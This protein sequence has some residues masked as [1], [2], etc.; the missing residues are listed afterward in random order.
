MRSFKS[1][2]EL[3]AHYAERGEP[4]SFAQVLDFTRK[5]E[6]LLN[7]RAKQQE[8]KKKLGQRR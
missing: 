8:P 1:A 7:E 6:A 4:D 5:C 3:L 2:D